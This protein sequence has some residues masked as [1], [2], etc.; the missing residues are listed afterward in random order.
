MILGPHRVNDTE[1]NKKQA[2]HTS[3]AIVI[4]KGKESLRAAHV[5]LHVPLQFFYD[6]DT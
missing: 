2:Q 6:Q 3:R 4:N 1:S 5:Q